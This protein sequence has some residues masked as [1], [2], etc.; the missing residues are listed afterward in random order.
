MTNAIVD[1]QTGDVVF[2]SFAARNPRLGR[3]ALAVQKRAAA[4]LC[5]FLS[6]G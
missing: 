5:G 2:Q 6:K 1:M 4:L 3:A